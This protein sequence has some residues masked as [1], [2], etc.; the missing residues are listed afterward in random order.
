MKKTLSI[1]LV[2]AMTLSAVGMTAFAGTS[3]NAGKTDPSLEKLVAKVDVS[4]Q[5]KFDELDLNADGVLTYEE[6]LNMNYTELNTPTKTFKGWA[7]TSDT[8]PGAAGT[9]ESAK[10]GNKDTLTAATGTFYVPAIY[11]VTTDDSKIKE[12]MAAMGDNG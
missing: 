2:A 4:S 9:D 10:K 8:D 12:N 1:A 7:A 3:Y 6:A 5:D 11:S